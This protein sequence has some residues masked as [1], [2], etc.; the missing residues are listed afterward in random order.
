VPVRKLTDRFVRFGIAKKGKS[1]D[2]D[3]IISKRNAAQWSSRSQQL[4]NCGQSSLKSERIWLAVGAP[5]EEE[6]LA[7]ADG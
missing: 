7:P 1:L 4:I 6:K 5:L 2:V 3:P